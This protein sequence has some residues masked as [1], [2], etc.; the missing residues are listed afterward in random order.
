VNGVETASPRLLRPGAD[1]PSPAALRLAA[2]RCFGQPGAGSDGF[3]ALIGAGTVSRQQYWSRS[4]PR[5][6]LGHCVMAAPGK[7]AAKSYRYNSRDKG[8]YSG[9][10]WLSLRIVHN[11]RFS[12]WPERPVHFLNHLDRPA[13][14][15]EHY[16]S[17]D[18]YLLNQKLRASVSLGQDW[19]SRQAMSGLAR[20]NGAFEAC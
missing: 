20:R 8:S 6:R 14:T 18:K 17:R 4:F 12:S 15:S 7:G 10:C 2:T 13:T 3:P 1:V 16:K 19:K 11:F 9:R 5:S